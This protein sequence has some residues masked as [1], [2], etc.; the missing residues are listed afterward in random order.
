MSWLRSGS[1]PWE[2]SLK[3]IKLDPAK[4]SVSEGSPFVQG[5][6]GIAYDSDDAGSGGQ[7]PGSSSGSS[8]AVGSYELSQATIDDRRLLKVV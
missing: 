3:Q 4:S 1:V 6:R 2:G 8:R 5:E 7:S